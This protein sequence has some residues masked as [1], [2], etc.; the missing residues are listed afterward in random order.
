MSNL[1]QGWE[2]WIAG[3]GPVLVT[4]NNLGDYVGTG[5]L[6]PATGAGTPIQ[7]FALEYVVNPHFGPIDPEDGP[8]G[9]VSYSTYY[10]GVLVSMLGGLSPFSGV[11]SGINDGRY[12]ISNTLQRGSNGQLLW[13]PRLVSPLGY[14]PPSLGGLGGNSG[15]ANALNNSNQVV[16]WSLKAN[17][18]QHAFL[19]SNGSMQDL[20]LLV[21]PLSGITLVSAVGI[22]SAG[23]IVAYGTNASGQMQE[24]YL[25]PDGV[26]HRTKHAGRDGPCDRV[27]RRSP[28]PGTARDCISLL[29]VATARRW[30]IAVE[31]RPESMRGTGI[32]ERNG[33]LGRG[34]GN[35]GG[36]SFRWRV[37]RPR[38]PRHASLAPSDSFS[39]PCASRRVVHRGRAGSENSAR[40]ARAGPRCSW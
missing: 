21:P 27:S 26:P 32:R 14:G 10:T 11:V 22:D 36:S 9:T 38:Q 30:T 29:A 1:T 3:P 8:P 23:D 35:S 34:T 7:N 17:G 5:Q 20:N 12:T 13:T 33:V 6:V 31:R 25:S 39:S 16:G 37:V 24:Y 28:R 18:V 2:H 15:M 40:P 19:Y 4:G